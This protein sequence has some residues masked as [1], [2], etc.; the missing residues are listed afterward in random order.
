MSYAIMLGALGCGLMGLGAQRG[1]PG[2]VIVWLGADFLA[3]SVAHAVGGHGLS[4]KRADGTIPWWS[5]V[6]FLPLTL[7]LETVWRVWRFGS[8]EPAI[9]RVNDWLAVGSRPRGGEGYEAFDIVVDLTAEFED[10]SAIRR[11]T[12][13]RAF[14]ILDGSSPDEEALRR[15]LRSL[16]GE[17]IFVHCA[18]GHGRTGLV[19]AALLIERGT[20]DSAE[21]AVRV[22]QQARPKIALNAG[23]WKCL[24]AYCGQEGERG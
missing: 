17:R 8:R 14:P 21:D 11:R 16:A 18:Q 6:V 13:Y 19:A 15:I 12:G 5:R 24:R 9:S 7:V 10:P 1:W 20:A 23:Q 4:G 22:L 2:G 3:L